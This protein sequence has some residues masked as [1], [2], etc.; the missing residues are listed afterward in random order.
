MSWAGLWG[1][2]SDLFDRVDFYSFTKRFTWFIAKPGR[3]AWQE[4]VLGTEAASQKSWKS[5]SEGAEA[6]TKRFENEIFNN[7]ASGSRYQI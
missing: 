6:E 3:I 4:A 1:L 5:P 2:L 7:D